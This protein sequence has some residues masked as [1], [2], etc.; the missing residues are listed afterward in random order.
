MKIEQKN[1]EKILLSNGFTIAPRK[2]SVAIANQAINLNS[3]SVY[4]RMINRSEVS[5]DAQVEYL[6]VGDEEKLARVRREVQTGVRANQRVSQLPEPFYHRALG[7]GGVPASQSITT[8]AAKSEMKEAQGGPVKAISPRQVAQTQA[9]SLPALQEQQFK[10]TI[11]RRT[12]ATSQPRPRMGPR[13]QQQAERI[14]R[15][16]MLITL[17]YRRPVALNRI[18]REALRQAEAETGLKNKP[19]RPDAAKSQSK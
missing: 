7:V 10:K 5:E 12:K 17:N 13:M 3:N 14:A 1:V 19:L 16:A 9:K 18:Q 15:A 2:Q 11:G 6:V 8:D 4:N